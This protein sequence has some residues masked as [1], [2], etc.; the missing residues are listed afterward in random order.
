MDNLSFVKKLYRGKNCYSDH[1]DFSELNKI[2]IP[3]GIEEKIL[4]FLKD[5]RIVFLTG[6]PGDG[7]T[8]IIR[9]ME[10]E[11]KKMHAYVETDLTQENA[12]VNT[13]KK[14]VECYNNNIPAII[15]ANE[16]PFLLLKKA[17]IEESDNL[18]EELLN[19][20]D[21]TISY[22]YSGTIKLDKI[23]VIDLNERNLLSRDNNTSEKILDKL[24]ELLKDE[25]V[26]NCLQHNIKALSTV[27]TK[28]RVI[29][30]INKVSTGVDHFVIRDVLGAFAYMLTACLIEEDNKLFYYDVMFSNENVLLRSLKKYDPL[31]L[32]D[33]D[34]DE[35]LWNGEIT[36]GWYY[37]IPKVFPCDVDDI[38]EATECFKSIKRKYYFE[39]AHGNLLEFKA[40]ESSDLYSIF[41]KFESHK[42]RIKEEIIFSLNKLFLPSSNDK[43]QLRIWTTHRYDVS[44]E[45]PI[46]VSSRYINS[47]DLD[48]EMP[49]PADWIKGMEYTPNHLIL[50]PKNLDAPILY[51]DM[52]FL[53]A[54]KAIE[55]GYPIG[56]LPSHYEQAT[57]MFLQRLCESNLVDENEG[58]EIIIASRENNYKTIITTQENKYSFE[59]D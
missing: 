49:R 47:S 52:D 32:T 42:K 2:H 40:D 56:L 14:I 31:Y 4:D 45:A 53:F 48:L 1:M 28:E 30:I 33:F 6:N 26:N 34:L 50:K 17:I 10:E 23:V 37:D 58:D 41:T 5:N 43:K 3:S 25:K 51:L 57:S 39:H 38:D 36:D 19:A 46:A 16:Y 12:Y 29:S 24:C 55:N 15:A 8:F 54:L 59:E 11:I 44:R 13:A 20:I 18:R 27:E 22:G 21:K 35:K 7:K 9:T